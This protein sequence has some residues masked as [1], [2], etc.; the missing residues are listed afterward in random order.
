MKT[1]RKMVLPVVTGVTALALAAPAGAASADAGEK[2]ENA[3]F[4]TAKPSL[5]V[6]GAPA[7]AAQPKAKRQARTAQ[8]MSSCFSYR[9]EEHWYAFHVHMYNGCSYTVH[10]KVYVAF[11]PDSRCFDFAPRQ[12]G[13]YWWTIGRYDG[14]GPC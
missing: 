13:T 10:A 11:G 6:A 9:Y 3:G 8:A 4:V 1:L 5:M 7:Q 12:G 2:T 14:V